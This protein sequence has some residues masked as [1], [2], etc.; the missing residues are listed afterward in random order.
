MVGMAVD[1]LVVDTTTGPYA[2]WVRRTKNDDP[3]KAY[4]KGP[5]GQTVW[6]KKAIKDGAPTQRVA[7]IAADNEGPLYECTCGF[8]CGTQKAFDKHIGRGLAGKHELLKLW[9]RSPNSQ[10]P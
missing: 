1:E 8:T 6:E 3:S 9:K 7:E 2:G 10:H 4:L 5:N